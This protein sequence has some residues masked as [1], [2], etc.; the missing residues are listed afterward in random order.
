MMFSAIQVEW[1]SKEP[2]FVS[3][4]AIEVLRQVFGI[5]RKHPARNTE[6]I[7]TV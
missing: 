3:L 4:T 5:S 6:F 1:N 2:L 7:I